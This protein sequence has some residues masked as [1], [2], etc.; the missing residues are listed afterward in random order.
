MSPCSAIIKDSSKCLESLIF[1]ELSSELDISSN[2]TGEL[3]NY[4]Q[5]LFEIGIIH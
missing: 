3:V 5:H 4:K 1:F 2:S